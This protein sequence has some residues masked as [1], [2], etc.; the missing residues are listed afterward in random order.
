MV[1][2]ASRKS[3]SL[4]LWPACATTS[5]N[6]L[7]GQAPTQVLVAPASGRAPDSANRVADGPVANGSV[8]V[9]FMVDSPTSVLELALPF[10]EMQNA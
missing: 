7:Y 6:S 1:G 8:N 2:S 9:P 3:S 4:A 5:L 10:E